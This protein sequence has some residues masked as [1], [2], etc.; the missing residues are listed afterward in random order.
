V[1]RLAGFRALDPD[2]VNRQLPIVDLEPLP[3]ELAD[4]VT[5]L[6]G[7]HTRSA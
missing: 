7:Q 6:A 5:G 2:H 3:A 1:A 4:R